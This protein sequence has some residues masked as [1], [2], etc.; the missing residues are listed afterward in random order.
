M[1]KDI[2]KIGA[3]SLVIALAVFHFGHVNVAPLGGSL[4]TVKQTLAKGFTSQADSDITGGTFTLT[5]KTYVGAG[6][7]TI[8][9]STRNV[10]GIVYTDVRQTMAIATTTPCAI[11]SPAATT[12]VAFATGAVG[13]NFTVSSTTASVLTVAT[14]TTAFA[15][16]SAVAI[17][18]IAANAQITVVSTTTPANGGIVLPPRSWLVFGLSGGAGT[19]SPTGSCTA[20]FKGL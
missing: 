17:Q 13:A 16:T 14:S 6:G 1:I 18:S 8:A 5:S 12:S 11:Q 3:V 4:E 7:V 15:T 2:L 10:S 19:F 20:S 9:S